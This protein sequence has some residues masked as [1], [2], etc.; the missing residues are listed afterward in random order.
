MAEKHNRVLFV[1]K[2]TDIKLFDS[3]R[4]KVFVLNIKYHQTLVSSFD[5][6]PRNQ[7]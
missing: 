5:L 7:G 2:S 3:F 4:R 1:N 6:G